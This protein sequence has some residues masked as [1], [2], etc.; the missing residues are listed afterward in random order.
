MFYTTKRHPSVI[1]YVLADN[2]SNGICLYESY[3]ALKAV[4]SDR[5]LFYYDGGKE[6]N[7]DHLK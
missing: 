1:A 7:T 5:P 3:L 4:V 2:S 6:W